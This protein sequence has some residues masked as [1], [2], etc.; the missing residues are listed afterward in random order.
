[1]PCL[2]VSSG[3]YL[4]ANLALGRL[5]K[6]LGRVRLQII[7][8]ISEAIPQNVQPFFNALKD[9]K[10]LDIILSL[11]IVSDPHRDSSLIPIFRNMTI[12][13]FFLDTFGI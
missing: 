8:L 9:E 5:E 12:T 13:P 2:T 3:D 4:L 11:F 7:R 6:P 10:L 1:M